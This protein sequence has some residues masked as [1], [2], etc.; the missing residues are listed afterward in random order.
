M[1]EMNTIFHYMRGKNIKAVFFDMDGTLF[2]SEVGSIEMMKELALEH[3]QIETDLA[4]EELLGLTPAEQLKKILGFED[5]ELLKLSEKK[6]DEIY[7]KIAKPIAGVNEC[8]VALS[9]SPN[10]LKFAVCTNGYMDELRPAFDK[11]PIKLDLYLGAGDKMKK[12]PEPDVYLAALKHFGLS[13][14][15]VLV[16]EDSLIGVSAALAA[17]IPE[18]NILIFDPSEKYDDKQTRFTSWE[19]FSQ[20]ERAEQR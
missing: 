15:E 12:K 13:P 11:L 9:L 20:D 16:A 14:K 19:E 10:N 2:D 6:G 5:L 3:H 7:A 18:D 8:L 4:I 1:N 17:K